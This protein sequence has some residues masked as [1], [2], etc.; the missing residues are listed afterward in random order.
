M[1]NTYSLAL[2]KASSQYA[3]I[4][5]A[6][7]TGLDIVGDMTIECWIMLSQLPSTAGS[8]MVIVSKDNVGVSRSYS[9]LVQSADDKLLFATFG[10]ASTSTR[11]TMDEAF[12][13][14]DVGVWIHVAAVID[15]STSTITF[16]KNTVSKAA[17]AVATTATDITSGS[18]DVLVGARL[19]SGSPELYF[20]GKI[21][22]LRIWDDIRTSGEISA[23]WISDTLASTTNLQ[24]RWKFENDYVDETSNNNDLTAVNTPTFSTSVPYTTFTRSQV[25]SMGISDILSRT[26]TINQSLVDSVGLTDLLASMIILTGSLV[27]TVGI[28][29]VT[30]EVL[31]YSRSIVDS[32]GLTDLLST[33]LMD[34]SVYDKPVR[35]DSADNYKGQLHDI[36]STKVGL[37]IIQET[38]P[39]LELIDDK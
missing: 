20:D 4:S 14:G 18:A 29:D 9:L 12:V 21:D 1:A 34:T 32:E 35:L 8:N 33:L 10:S 13:G 24:A 27:D 23:N 39:T 5:D 36:A 30:S 11:F 17:T 31:D 16:F 19:S 25:D 3:Y 26:A 2:A 6:S 38:K 15:V 7:Q 37:V 22:D 28:T